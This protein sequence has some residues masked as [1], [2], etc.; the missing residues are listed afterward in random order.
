MSLAAG[1]AK[2]IAEVLRDE[3]DPSEAL[4]EIGVHRLSPSESREILARRNDVC[5]ADL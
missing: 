2:L 3:T 5:A 1:S 4:A